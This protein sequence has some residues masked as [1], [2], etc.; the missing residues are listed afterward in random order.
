MNTVS[1]SF[2]FTGGGAPLAKYSRCQLHRSRF[3]TTHSVPTRRCVLWPLGCVNA[4]HQHYQWLLLDQYRIILFFFLLYKK[5]IYICHQMS[6]FLLIYTFDPTFIW[7]CCTLVITKTR[8][9]PQSMI[10]VFK[11]CNFTFQHLALLTIACPLS[12]KTEET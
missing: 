3:A 6:L 1:N 7:T 5:V 12:R 4:S 9:E 2:L 11:D 8:S 10:Q